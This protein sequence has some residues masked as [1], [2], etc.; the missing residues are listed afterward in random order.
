MKMPF[1]VTNYTRR[2]HAKQYFCNKKTTMSILLS[3]IFENV[4]N[5]F[6]I[7]AVRVL[8]AAGILFVVCYIVY[9]ILKRIFRWKRLPTRTT[10]ARENER[11]EQELLA[12]SEE[13]ER[14]MKKIV[15]LES[16]VM[17]HEMAPG[18]SAGKQLLN[19]GSLKVKCDHIAYIVP[20]S[21]EQGDGGNARIKV[22]HYTDSSVTDSVYSNFDSILEQLSG[23]FMLINK[24][25]IINLKEVHKIQGLEVYLKNVRSPFYVSETK[26]EEL[27]IRMA[28]LTQ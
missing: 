14:L 20:Q 18:S 16:E 3:A 13:R 19:I 11:L 7:P 27:D 9:W 4:F 1:F 28:R 15:Q 22:I 25:Q 5:Y 17:K 24:N 8:F 10:L 23:H 12:I 21:L 6:V 2:L 26:K